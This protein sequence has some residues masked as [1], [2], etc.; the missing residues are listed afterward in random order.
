[1][2]YRKV[3]KQQ[4]PVSLAEAWNFFSDPSNLQTITPEYMNFII[5]SGKD[6]KKTY[7]GQIIMY[8]VSPMMN[9][10]LNWV[11]EIT[12]VN[13][14]HYFVDEQRKGPYKLWHHQHHFRALSADKTEMTDILHYEV[15][16]GI[17]GRILNKLMI[18][19]KVDSIFQYREKKLKALFGE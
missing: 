10:P 1:M 14:P 9:L 8:T 12:H 13:E 18:N 2:V 7:P 15:P 16:A 19:K 6:D 17:I 3:F 4:L 11:T 5:R